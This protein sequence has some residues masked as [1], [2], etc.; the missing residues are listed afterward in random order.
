MNVDQSLSHDQQQLQVH[1]VYQSIKNINSVLKV[2]EVNHLT[3]HDQDHVN[4]VNGFG[5]GGAD[6]DRRNSFVDDLQSHLIDGIEYG[7]SYQKLQQIGVIQA[8]QNGYSGKGVNILVIDSGFL[9]DHESIKSCNI[10]AEKDFINNT[11]NTQGQLGDVQNRH[12]TNVL[13]NIGGWM[14]GSIIGVA[15]KA[16]YILA[17][18]EIID[19]EVPVEEDYLISAL[20]WGHSQGARVASIS[21]GYSAWFK[22]WEV[23]GT[24]SISKA[25]DIAHQKG[26]LVV[27]SSGNNGVSGITPPSDCRECISVG[28]VDNFDVIATFSSIGPTADGRR[29]PEVVGPGMLIYSA[30]ASSPSSY[31]FVSGTSISTPLIAGS[32]ALVMEA[33][34]DWTPSMVREALISTASSISSPDNYKGYGAI[35]IKIHVVS[36]SCVDQ[37]AK[38]TVENVIQTIVTGARILLIYHTKRDK[39]QSV[40]IQCSRTQE[41]ILEYDHQVP[42]HF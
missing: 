10:I 28:A 13:S 16:N 40:E 33:H 12:G 41:P 31:E 2:S 38:R 11:G 8:H 18:T 23:D 36:M 3:Y 9:K 14:P 24:S 42:I 34:P 17:K 7:R 15:H 37:F 1:N 29:K 35:N 21:L 22:Y 25:V 20:E 32:A 5:D 4:N 19:K 26:M 27:V 39:D 30:A 6:M